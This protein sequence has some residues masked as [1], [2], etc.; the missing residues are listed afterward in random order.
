M[1]NN[2][3]NNK[4]NNGN[5]QQQYHCQ[6]VRLACRQRNVDG[7][8]LRERLMQF[9]LRLFVNVCVCVYGF[10]FASHRISCARDI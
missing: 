5:E 9:Y 7:P 6:C 2:N 8:L 4:K 10:V 1:C 3:N